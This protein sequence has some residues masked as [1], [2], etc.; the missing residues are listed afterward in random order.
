MPPS[1]PTR[2]ARLLLLVS[3]LILAGATL[4][5]SAAHRARAQQPVSASNPDVS[6][7]LAKAAEQGNV[8]IIVGV[9]TNFQPEGE[10]AGLQEVQAQRSSIQ[11]AQ[12]S[13]LSSLPA[14]VAQT[15]Y[16][17]KFIPFVVLEADVTTLNALAQHPIV[18]SIAEDTP[19]APMMNESIPMIGADVVHQGGNGYTGEGVLQGYVSLA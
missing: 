15:A 4:A 7:L 17:Y 13:L 12:R 5:A 10:L 1:I 16:Q 11:R 14:T 19:I 8:R 2:N 9:D 3:L 18:T 6:G